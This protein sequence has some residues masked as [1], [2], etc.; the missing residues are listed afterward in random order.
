MLTLTDSSIKAVRRFLKNAPTLAEG[1]RVTITG[2][3]CSG[4]QYGLKL[5]EAAA[6]GDTVVESHGVKI[7]IDP[8]SLPLIDGAIIDFVDSLDGSGFKFTNPNA[9]K[10]C[11]CGNSFSA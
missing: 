2:G 1:L 6:A 10:N 3:G 11:S 4:F 9:K 7:F 5:E 8:A